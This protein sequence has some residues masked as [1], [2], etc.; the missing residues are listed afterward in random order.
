MQEFILTLMFF[1]FMIST[2][3]RYWIQATLVICT[4]TAIAVISG[5]SWLIAASLSAALV[6]AWAATRSVVT[7]GHIQN[8]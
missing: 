6:V 5:G 8:S 2:L 4:V 3:R 1:G 7:I